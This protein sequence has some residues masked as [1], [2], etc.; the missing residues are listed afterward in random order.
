MK[1]V[2]KLNGMFLI[3]YFKSVKA[4]QH[5]CTSLLPPSIKVYLDHS[6]VQAG[7]WHHAL[8]HYQWSNFC[9]S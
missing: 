8:K 4:H 1:R 6:L 9:G 7:E 2:Y 3:I 5:V